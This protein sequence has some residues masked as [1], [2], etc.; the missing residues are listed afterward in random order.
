MKVSA[1]MC[2]KIRLFFQPYPSN[3]GFVH[4][5]VCVYVFVYNTAVIPLH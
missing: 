3:R 1:E 2:P 5:M 4:W